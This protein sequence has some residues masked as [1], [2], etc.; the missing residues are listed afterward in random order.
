MGKKCWIWVACHETGFARSAWQH[1]DNTNLGYVAEGGAG[2]RRACGTARR[3]ARNT[4]H[5]TAREQ[6]RTIPF[7]INV[8]AFSSIQLSNYRR[9]DDQSEAQGYKP[10]ITYLKL[11]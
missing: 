7:L 5:T 10:L 9:R 2:R 3:T 1:R 4:A 8:V 6:K 11:T